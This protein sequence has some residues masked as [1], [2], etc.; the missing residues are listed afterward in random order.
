MSF[1][2]PGDRKILNLGRFDTENEAAIVY[3][4]A[5]VRLRGPAAATNLALSNYS[6][7][8][9]EYYK[10]QEVGHA[11]ISQKVF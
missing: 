4:Q 11:I 9:A 6:D 3:D 2:I 5:L 1:C 7:N 8:L 10:M